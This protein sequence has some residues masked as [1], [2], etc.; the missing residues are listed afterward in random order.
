MAAEV[1]VKQLEDEKTDACIRSPLKRLWK[2]YRE[3]LGKRNGAKV[4]RVWHLIG[5]IGLGTN[6]AKAAKEARRRR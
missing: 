6:D 1:Q 5:R 2:A 3:S 4:V